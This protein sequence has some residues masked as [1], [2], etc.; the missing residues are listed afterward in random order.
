MRKWKFQ[1][2]IFYFVADFRVKWANQR[3]KMRE[4]YRY[5]PQQQ[6]ELETKNIN[7]YLG[8]AIAAS[9]ITVRNTSIFLS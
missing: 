6:S 8:Y 5:L 9:I 3:D 4:D 2:N 1:G 7:S